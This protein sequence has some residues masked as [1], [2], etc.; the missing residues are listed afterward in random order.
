MSIS[1][2]FLITMSHQLV[3][4]I[5]CLRHDI[6]GG[7]KHFV[8]HSTMKMHIANAIRLDFLRKMF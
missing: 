3:V 5:I 1:I 6:R 2:D 8:F 4:R 7:A